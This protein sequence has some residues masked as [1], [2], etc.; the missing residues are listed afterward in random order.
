MLAKS[1]YSPRYYGCITLI[2]LKRGVDVKTLSKRTRI[3][4]AD[5]DNDCIEIWE[6]QLAQLEEVE[7]K[8][9]FWAFDQSQPDPETIKTPKKQLPLLS[10]KFSDDLD[11]DENPPLSLCYAPE[12]KFKLSQF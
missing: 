5:Y 12:K 10:N 2:K 7:Q 8:S 11:L 4:F 1:P 3:L 6:N 9:E